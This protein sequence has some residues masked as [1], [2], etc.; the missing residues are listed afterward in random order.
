M[1]RPQVPDPPPYLQAAPRRV[2]SSVQMWP[3][4]YLKL[5]TAADDST[6][7]NEAHA[8]AENTPHLQQRINVQLVSVQR[9]QPA[10]RPWGRA[11]SLRHVQQQPLRPA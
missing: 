5:S 7:L 1:T 6:N 10:G 2:I 4:G 9:P 8:A 3:V 11:G